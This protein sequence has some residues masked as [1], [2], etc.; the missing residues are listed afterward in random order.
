MLQYPCMAESR[1]GTKASR[2][3]ATTEALLVAYFT[4]WYVLIKITQLQKG[5]I[6]LIHAALDILGQSAISVAHFLGGIIYATVGTAEKRELQQHQFELSS[7]YILD[8]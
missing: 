7:D 5:E 1:C 8:S 6:V 2:S 4:A 3:F